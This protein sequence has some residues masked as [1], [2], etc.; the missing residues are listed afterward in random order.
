[1]PGKTTDDY[2]WSV[3]VHVR[4]FFKSHTSYEFGNYFAP[5]QSPLSRLEFPMDTWWAGAEARR[6]FMNNRFSAGIEVMRNISRETDGVMKD[7]DW[8]DD[9]NPSRK[10]IYSESNCRMEPSYSV[11]ADLDMSVADWLRLPA[12]L[13]LRP[14]IGVRWQRLTFMIHDGSQSDVSTGQRALLGD[15]LHFEQV[16]WHYFLG[17]KSSYDLGRPFKLKRLVV[18]TQLDWA[19]VEGKNEDQ[20]LLHPGNR[21][22][23]ETT[24]GDAVHGA[25]GIKAG[26]TERVNLGLEL[27][28]LR[29]KTTGTHR[30]ANDMF[31]INISWTNGVQVWSEQTSITMSLQYMF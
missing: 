17:L 31:G 20:H 7:S 2:P 22:T 24:Y 28:Y 1:M 30:L 10:T 13:D 18:T 14:V 23:Y 5:Y 25:I 11:R 27:D 15:L 4:S 21:F 19:Y 29:I 26:L 16:Y 6:S 12:G 9:G 8:D 3:D